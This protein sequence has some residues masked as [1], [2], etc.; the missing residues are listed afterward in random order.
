MIKI[1][2]IAIIASVIICMAAIF[3]AHCQ[4]DTSLKTIDGRVVS[5]DSQNSQIVIKTIET[6]TFS[7][8]SN[9]TIINKDGFSIQLSDI[10]P[11]NYAMVDY[12][13][14]PAGKHIAKNIEIEYNR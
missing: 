12:Y 10:N 4:D 5:T 6:L 9:T 13:D 14:T 11:G 2:S 3:P 1:S 8:S 7:V